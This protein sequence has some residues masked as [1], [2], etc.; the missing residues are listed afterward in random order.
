M[1]SDTDMPSGGDYCVVSTNGSTIN[2]RADGGT[3]DA[4]GVATWPA[5]EAE[6]LAYALSHEDARKMARELARDASAA[7]WDIT[8]TPYEPLPLQAATGRP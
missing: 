1:G 6:L 7:A 4:F 2:H 8:S 3:S 5:D